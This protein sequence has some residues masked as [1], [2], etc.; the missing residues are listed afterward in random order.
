MIFVD[1]SA[2][3][4][5]VVPSDENHAAAAAWLKLNT[6][7]LLTTNYIADETLTLLRARGE[8]TRALILGEKFF[9]SHLSEI[10]LLTEDDLLAAWEVFQRFDDKA[11]SFTD[12]T[13]SNHTR[14]AHTEP[15]ISRSF[16]CPTGTTANSP[17]HSVLWMIVM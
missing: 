1:T 11:W 9:R 16:L 12:C 15:C 6:E 3:Y 2:W 5:S 8:K 4:A 17:A 7:P 13:K 14:M 10:Y